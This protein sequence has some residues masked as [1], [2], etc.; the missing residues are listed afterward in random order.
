MSD[1]G[2]QISSAS[3]TSLDDEARRAGAVAAAM[4]AIAAKGLGGGDLNLAYEL[5]NL[6]T[7]ADQIQDALSAKK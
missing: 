2:Q 5:E 6:S 7:Y 1:I 4:E 3:N